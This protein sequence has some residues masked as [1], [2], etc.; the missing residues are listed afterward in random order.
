MINLLL[1]FYVYSKHL[2]VILSVQELMLVAVAL[3]NDNRSLTWDECSECQQGYSMFQK[4]YITRGPGALTLVNSIAKYQ[5]QMCQRM[6]IYALKCNIM[7]IKY[8]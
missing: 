4:K 2:S 8:V 7:K 1:L 3:K 6:Y 5:L